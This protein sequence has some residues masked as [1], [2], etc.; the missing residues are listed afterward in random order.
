VGIL[1]GAKPVLIA[2]AALAVLVGCDKSPPVPN[3]APVVAGVD[4]VSCADRVCEVVLRVVDADADPVDL[5][6]QCVRDAGA[7]TLTD[8]A[9]TDGRSGLE[10]DRAPPGRTHYLRLGVDGPEAT[11]NLKLRL[12]PTDARGLAG[13]AYTSPAFTLQSGL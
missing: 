3:A 8:A 1:A 7:C 9:G 10:P 6:V 11:E 5:D 4:A 2:T 12:L 13:D